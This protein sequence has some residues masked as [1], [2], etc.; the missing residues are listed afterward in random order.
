LKIGVVSDTH[1]TKIN[2]SNPLHQKFVEKVEEF[3]K[4]VDL[5][6]HAGDVGSFEVL[7]FLE[8]VAPVKAVYGNMDDLLIRRSLPPRLFVEVEEVRIGLTHGS[9]APWGIAERLLQEFSQEML[10]CLVFGHTHE[11][12]NQLVSGVLLFNPGSPTDTVYASQ[13][14]LGILMV[15]GKEIKGEI[16]SL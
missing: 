4:D 5:I 2:F 16:I 15:K 12:M 13:N 9:G 7:N 11:P 8:K 3:F 6:L 10:D 1:L 14:S